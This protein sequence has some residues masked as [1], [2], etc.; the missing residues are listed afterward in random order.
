MDGLGSTSAFSTSTNFPDE[1]RDHDRPQEGG[2]RLS[3]C[4][5]WQHQVSVLQSLSGHCMFGPMACWE[6]WDEPLS[7][8]RTRELCEE[9][10]RKIENVEIKIEESNV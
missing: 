2:D 10:L 9:S 5:Q 4:S 6:C 3:D 7:F 1:V 8:F